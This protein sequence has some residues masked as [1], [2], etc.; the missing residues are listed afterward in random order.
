MR[1]KTSSCIFYQFLSRGLLPYSWKYL[2]G[3]G[4][5]DKREILLSLG[6]SVLHRY[7]RVL[8]ARDE[9][10]RLF[11]MP[12]TR[13]SKD[14]MEYHFD[15]LTVLLT[16][17]LDVQTLII[18]NIY[19]LGL[20]SS[21]CGLRRKKFREAIRSNS[22]TSS[23]DTLLTTKD[24]FINILFDLRNKIHSISIETDFHVPETYPNELFE[25]IYKYDQSD[26]WGIQ[27][28]NVTVIEN[29]SDPVPSISYSVDMYNLA[30]SLVNEATNLINSFMEETKI[31]RFLDTEKLSKISVNP[32]DDMLPYI[33]TYLLLA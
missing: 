20:N 7:S 19:C 13:S 31:E 23:L 14:Q 1:F 12:N 11:Y 2:S 27:K 17:A 22:A 15:Y 6:W 3:L 16:A 33:Q 26:H 9:I 8:Q 32:P 4:L 30:Y 29:Y 10:G 5:H 24:N 21:D 25:R 18:N 28:Q